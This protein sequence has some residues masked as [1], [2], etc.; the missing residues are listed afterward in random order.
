MISQSVGDLDSIPLPGLR[1][2]SWVVASS[3]RASRRAVGS[4]GPS[5]HGAWRPAPWR[6]VGGLE[7]APLAGVVLELWGRGHDGI[8]GNYSA[9][10]RARGRGVSRA[11]RTGCEDP[12][13]GH[14]SLSNFGGEFR[15]IGALRP[16]PPPSPPPAGGA[17]ISTLSR[18]LPAVLIEGREGGAS[19]GGD[20]PSQPP[21][22]NPRGRGRREERGL[23]RDRDT[24]QAMKPTRRRPVPDVPRQPSTLERVG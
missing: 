23:G 5:K 11:L 6:R 8:G 9:P 20:M 17:V 22:S 7:H 19:R 18:A 16:P 2:A 21:R 12:A 15:E 10:S 4:P 14:D 1:T 3:A 13:V 24:H